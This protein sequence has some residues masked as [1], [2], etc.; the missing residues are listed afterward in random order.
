MV[1]LNKNNYGADKN[2]LKAGLY[3]EIYIF[4]SIVSAI[5]KSKV[6]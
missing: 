4:Y 1:I 2:R 6:L 3:K 5:N